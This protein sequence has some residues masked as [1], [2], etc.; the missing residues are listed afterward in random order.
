MTR[1]GRGQ[2]VHITIPVRRLP[3]SAKSPKSQIGKRPTCRIKGEGTTKF[4][5]GRIVSRYSGI[6]LSELNQIF[7]RGTFVGL[8]DHR[9][10]ERFVVERDETAFAALV[11]RHGPMVLGVCRRHPAR[12]T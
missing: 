1:A 3:I 10:L 12:G 6:M 8:N 2:L 7:N 5:G 11:A 4:G 9:L